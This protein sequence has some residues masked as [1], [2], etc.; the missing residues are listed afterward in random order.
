MEE[1]DMVNAEGAKER[2]R[3][4]KLI[5]RVCFHFCFR[6]SPVP[7]H[8]FI[9]EPEVKWKIGETTKFHTFFIYSG[10]FRPQ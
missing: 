5:V 2:E 10:G 9:S 1:R 4:K 6:S 8:S 7:G 3:E